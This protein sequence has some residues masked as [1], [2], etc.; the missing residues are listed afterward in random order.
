MYNTL[1]ERCFNECVNDFSKKKLG[2]K[3]ELCVFRC[4]DK[5]I[6]VPFAAKMPTR[7]R[8]VIYSHSS[9]SSSSSFAAS[10]LIVSTNGFKSNPLNCKH[11]FKHSKVSSRRPSRS[12]NR[13]MIKFCFLIVVYAVK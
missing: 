13:K 9:S 3:E 2:S 7:L 6:K 4:T 12:S 8:H 10:T 11:R 1:V 5:F